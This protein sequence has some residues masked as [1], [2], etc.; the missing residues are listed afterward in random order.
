MRALFYPLFWLT[1]GILLIVAVIALTLWP[2]PIGAIPSSMSD[3]TG[4]VIAY[5]TLMSWFAGL[6]PRQRHILWAVFFVLLG[7]G[8]EWL[9][10]FV[11]IRMTELLDA[12]ANALGAA[13]GLVLARL[14]LDQ[15][16]VWF[17]RFT[18]RGRNAA[19]G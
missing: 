1:I 14:G 18:P 11:E 12:G 16:C 6:Y 4:H 15:W 19:H 8:L 10:S 9:Q 17:E 13:I 7:V 5:F 2:E 3:K